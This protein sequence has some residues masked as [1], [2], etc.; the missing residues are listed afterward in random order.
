MDRYGSVQKKYFSTRKRFDLIANGSFYYVD[1]TLLIKEIVETGT[2]AFLFTRPRRFGKTTN[3]DMLDCFFNVDDEDTST[4]FNDLKIAQYP[5]IM[6]ERGKYRVIHLDLSESNAPGLDLQMDRFRIMISRVM[7]KHAYILSDDD[8]D[9]YNRSL[10]ASFRDRT[11]TEAELIESINYLCEWIDRFDHRETVIL[12]DEY[13]KPVHEA[14][15]NG[16]YEG[17]M[18]FFKMFLESTLKRNQNYTYAV[19]TGVSHIS[20]ES[21]FSGLNNLMEYDVFEELYDEYFGFT[22]EEISALLGEMGIP[23]DNID[24][25]RDY[26]DGYRFGNRDV[27]NPF[28]VMNHLRDHE[29]GKRTFKPYWVSSG[30]TSILSLALSHT[31]R[32]FI[33]RVLSLGIPGNMIHAD[34]SPYLNM[35]DVTSGK[36]EERSEMAVLTLMVTSGYLKAVLCKDGRYDLMIP[37]TEVFTAFEQISKELRVVDVTTASD[38][39]GSILSL[40]SERSTEELNRILE[41]QSPRDHYDERTHKLMLSCLFGYSGY[42]YQNELASGF[43]FVD[44]YVHGVNN[45]PGMLIELKYT[46]SEDEDLGELASSALEQIRRKDYSRNIKERHVKVGIAY[47]MNKASVV[48]SD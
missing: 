33:E 22:E 30:D 1:K 31:D 20:K 29:R 41:G 34:I 24:C 15:T 7:E 25:I 6:E 21:I 26:Y 48:I 36:D 32:D 12:I 9:E 40:Q 2:G 14:V 11:A 44:V 27:Y 18:A 23:A 8:F 16:Y 37:N 17:F 4:I 10:F 5:E 35:K 38:L 3:L 13:D 42:R 19:I 47:H 28:S 45:G 46:G 39:V 43:G